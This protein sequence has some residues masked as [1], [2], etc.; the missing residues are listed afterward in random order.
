[1]SKTNV[2]RHSIRN[3]VIGGVL[4]GLILAAILYFV[5]TFTHWA[6]LLIAR[7]WN[8]I[9]A[10]W[11][12]LLASVAVPR[13]ILGLLIL[14]SLVT[15]VRVIRPLFKS[16]GVAEPTWLSYSQDNFFGMVWRWDST[17]RNPLDTLRPF[18]PS[19]DTRLVY[20]MD[21]RSHDFTTLT[22]FICET[23]QKEIAKLEGDRDYV[24]AKVGRQIERKIRNGEWKQAISK[25]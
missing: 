6:S 19:C 11:H 10:T 15:V 1:M 16:Q 24:L 20:S 7:V 14:M 25:S 3:K 2:E 17:S 21:V 18:C 12:Y 9:A 13:C 4:S 8:L 5:P 23:C 22:G